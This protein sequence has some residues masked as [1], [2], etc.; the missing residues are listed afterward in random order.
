MSFF[1]VITLVAFLLFFNN[2]IKKLYQYYI[3][4]NKIHKK[5][6]SNF[7]LVFLF[8]PTMFFAVWLMI[9]IGMYL[10]SLQ[11][12]EYPQW[13]FVFD[14]WTMIFFIGISLV[15]GSTLI[16]NQIDDVKIDKTNNKLFLLN[17]YL[18]ITV[19]EKIHKM[20]FVLGMGLLL[21]V[22]IYNFIIGLIIFLF[23]DK[24]YNASEFSWKKHPLLGPFCNLIV[25]IL[26]MM[27]GW[28]F[29]SCSGKYF[30]FS[31]SIITLKFFTGII[32][33]ILSYIAVALLTDIPDIK[34]DIKNN[35]TTFTIKYTEKVTIYISTVL[36]ISASFISLKLNDPLAS[37]A[38]ISSIPF[39]VYAFFRQYEKDILRAIRYPI[40]I[41]N[42]FTMTIYPYLFIGCFIIFYFSK[43]YYWYRF[44]LHYPTFLVE[45]D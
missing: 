8:R 17:G 7:D 44:D 10:S 36:V 35:K 28:V 38:I 18:G 32:P 29:V 40:F 27:S 37:T 15:V 19:A 33:Y 26:F 21:L 3:K 24:F 14:F 31:T 1:I 5:I 6:V 39:F 34:G 23:W 45:N 25:G 30:Y 11:I 13:I 12:Q 43:Y 20:S 4:E 9:A 42:F 16:Q 2:K 41:L 22:N